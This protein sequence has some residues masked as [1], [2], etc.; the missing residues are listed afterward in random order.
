MVKQPLH[1]SEY[2]LLIQRFD[3]Q[4][5]LI[6]A[7]FSGVNERLD[8]I[9]GKVGKHDEQ[10]NEALTERAKN[11]Q[12]Q[13]DVFTK[14]EHIEVKIEELKEIESKLIT[15]C[16]QAERVRD[17]EDSLLKIKAVKENGTLVFGRTAQIL[18][19]FIMFAGLT[20]SLIFSI[21]NYQSK[22]EIRYVPID[23]QSRFRGDE[24]DSVYHNDSL[25]PAPTYIIK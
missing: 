17:I 19:L 5:T 11:R 2:D 3:M 20:T 15:T 8:K 10:I 1:S 13:K 6:N 12:E 9:N 18:I 23:A 21:K 22:K 7:Q 25:N 16:P 24:L 4:T 14:V